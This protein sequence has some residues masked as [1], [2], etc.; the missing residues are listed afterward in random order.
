MRRLTWSRRR[1]IVRP[2]GGLVGGTWSELT[3]TRG[4][5][6]RDGAEDAD[7]VVERLQAELRALQELVRGLAG[8]GAAGDRVV[9]EVGRS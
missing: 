6:C 5:D 3:E 2:A 9:A 4:R 7:A 8:R 1:A